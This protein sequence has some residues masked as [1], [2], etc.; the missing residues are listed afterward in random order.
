M[1]S[2]RSLSFISI[3]L[4]AALPVAVAGDAP[5]DAALQVDRIFESWDSVHSPG[6]AVGVAQH[7]LTVL[8]RAYGMADLHT[9]DRRNRHDQLCDTGVHEKGRTGG[10]NP[11]WHQLG[12]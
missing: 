6:C 9:D 10:R 3:A 4:L 11:G 12:L 1:M 8:A 2:L 7:G 5:A